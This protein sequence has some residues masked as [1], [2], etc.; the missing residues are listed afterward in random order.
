MQSLERDARDKYDEP[1]ASEGHRFPPKVRSTRRTRTYAYCG[2]KAVRF[3]SEAR[4]FAAHSRSAPL[5]WSWVVAGSVEQGG[6]IKSTSFVPDLCTAPDSEC[7]HQHLEVLRDEYAA[8]AAD[9]EH[10]VAPRAT[11]DTVVAI[12][13]HIVLHH[14]Y[15]EPT[16]LIV[17][18][19]QNGHPVDEDCV[20]RLLGSGAHAGIQPYLTQVEHPFLGVPCLCLHPCRTATFMATMRG[21]AAREPVCYLAS[22]WSVMSN[23]LGVPN[24]A[25]WWLPPSPTRLSLEALPVDALY[26][27][28]RHLGVADLARIR[29]VCRT[30]CADHESVGDPTATRMAALWACQTAGV[31][32]A[33]LH[34]ASMQDLLWIA[35]RAAAGHDARLR[36]AGLVAAGG[37]CFPGSALGNAA[38]TLLARDG[39]AYAC[40]ANRHGQLGT[41]VRGDAIRLQRVQG[42]AAATIS[43]V[44]AGTVHSVALT[45]SGAVFAWGDN[46]YGQCALDAEVHVVPTPRLVEAIGDARAIGA[47]ASMHTLVVTAAGRVY[48]WGHNDLGQIGTG[49][50][51]IVQWEPVIVPCPSAIVAVSCSLSHSLAIDV[52][53]RLLAWGFGGN[54]QLGNGEEKDCPFP[55]LVG[56]ALHGQCAVSIA[57]A[58]YH[59]LVVVESGAVYV[60]G[61]GGQHASRL[62]DVAG[63]DH[64]SSKLRKVRWPRR[65]DALRGM[66]ALFVSAAVNHSLVV[67]VDPGTGLE[68][69]WSFG[70]GEHGKLG[71]AT[72]PAP[73]HV[74][75][76]HSSTTPTSRAV[77]VAAGNAHSVALRLDQHAA[78]PPNSVPDVFV[79]GDGAH[80]QCGLGNWEAVRSPAR[81]SPVEGRS[82]PVHS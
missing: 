23:L 37:G 68:E 73:G 80:G 64:G 62:G 13:F 34:A 9:D 21:D 47:A 3:E 59:S 54:G 56:G 51:V 49:K 15:R 77:V 75:L 78:T 11:A 36:L 81:L 58:D 48:G 71:R 46:S 31:A 32:P 50:R 14:T 65:V 69:V 66:T 63:P 43:A 6:Y 25:E 35:R 57:A 60:C 52:G 33:I 70:D 22:W 72:G 5:Q 8:E 30:L 74:D 38:H 27:V 39:V 26:A 44:A 2:M 76:P 67:V 19:K 41:G 28:L 7:C 45:W 16:L 10:I 18:A 20:L 82:S 40:G 55:T 24:R 79:W 4:T 1:K 29:R 53:G 42:L 12:T 17:G 61:Y